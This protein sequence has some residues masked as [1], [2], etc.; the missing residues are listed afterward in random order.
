MAGQ[1]SGFIKQERDKQAQAAQ[2][3]AARSAK[4]AE[5]AAKREAEA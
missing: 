4:A 1:V 5:D 2:A 3:A